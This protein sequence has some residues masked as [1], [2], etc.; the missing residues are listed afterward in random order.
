MIRF[1]DVSFSYSG[2]E[3][4]ALSHIN[5]AV[6]PGEFVGIIGGSGAGKTTLLRAANGTIPHMLHG[7]FY[8]SVTVLS[9]DTFSV[10][11]VAL[12]KTVGTVSDDIDA[13]AVTSVV[14]DEILF[15]LESFGVPKEEIPS[16]VDGA[17]SQ[18]G[19]SD[20]KTREI[21]SLSGGQKQ[22]VAIAA[23]LAL[24]PKILL[25]DE[26]TGELDPKSSKAVYETL[27]ALN[28]DFNI[29]VVVVEQKIMLLSEYA[30]RLIV[31]RGGEILLD[32]TVS[33]ALSKSR[34]LEECGVNC[35][36]FVTLMNRLREE[37]IYD[38][39]MP[40]TADQT[41]EAVRHILGREN[42]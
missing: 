12:S 16:R 19:I 26:P 7:D 21:S 2:S 10:S 41:A 5:L 39:K 38:G 28:R 1:S 8:G 13:Q 31:M 22:K 40:E 25:L 42:A 29:T 6:A 3:K 35:P 11:P 4:K 34:L 37:K 23:I 24:K 15:G 33:E 17:L 27:R 14:E 30:K 36:R 18:I 20:L 9:K 32:G